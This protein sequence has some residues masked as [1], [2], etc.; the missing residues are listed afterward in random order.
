MRLQQWW[1]EKLSCCLRVDASNVCLINAILFRY[2]IV[3]IGFLV[4]MVAASC[5]PAGMA[6]EMPS[7]DTVN[8]YL[9]VDGGWQIRITDDP[10]AP[11]LK[12]GDAIGVVGEKDNGAHRG[13]AAWH[14]TGAVPDDARLHRRPLYPP[15]DRTLVWTKEELAGRQRYPWLRSCQTTCLNAD[16][17][18][19]GR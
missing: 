4:L 10:A 13:S 17:F 12:P 15:A 18:H 1:R 9:P 16:A 8:C 14:T 19:F 3:R 2:F 6:S 5:L 11:R 7:A